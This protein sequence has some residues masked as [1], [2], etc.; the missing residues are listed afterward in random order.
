M[1]EKANTTAKPKQNMQL[2]QDL[3]GNPNDVNELLAAGLDYFS[4]YH[5]NNEAKRQS[6]C[7]KPIRAQAP[8][9]NVPD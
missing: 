8:H 2:L 4:F 9:Y 3:C 1:F 7:S 5:K 6:D